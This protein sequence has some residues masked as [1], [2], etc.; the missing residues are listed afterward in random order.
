[1]KMR[2]LLLGFFCLLIIGVGPYFIFKLYATDLTDENF[3][4]HMAAFI[5]IGEDEFP[6]EEGGY[7]WERRKGLGMET[8]QTDHAGPSQMAQYLEPIH[9]K[10][11]QKL[12]IKIEKD[13]D[14]AAV[15]LW[16]EEGRRLKEIQLDV[17]QIIVPSES[18]KY[19]YEVIANWANGSV[20]YTFV[21]ELK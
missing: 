17:N 6:I 13:P 14:I 8:V 3:P 9:V 18:G 4:P 21:V 10:P 5:T 16:N 1:M 15:Y 19:I 20:S 12:G 7:K 2:V 11:N